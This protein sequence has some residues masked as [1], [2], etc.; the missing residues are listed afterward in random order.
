M[1]WKS[2]AGIYNSYGSQVAAYA[3]AH[4]VKCDYTGIVRIGTNHKTTGGYEFQPYDQAET[5]NHFEEFRAAM[6][7]AN[8]EYRPFREDDI[9]DIPELIELNKAEKTES[10]AEAKIMKKVSKPKL[11]L[12]VGIK[13]KKNKSK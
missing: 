1:D 6:I 9:K 13:I 3:N 2:S 8:S 5:S 11:K 7:I 10:K 12:K 4:G